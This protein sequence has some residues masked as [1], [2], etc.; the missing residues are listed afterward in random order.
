MSLTNRGPRRGA[1]AG[2]PR[3]WPIAH[4]RPPAACVRAGMTHGQAGRGAG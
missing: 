3:R 4:A 1:E 2:A